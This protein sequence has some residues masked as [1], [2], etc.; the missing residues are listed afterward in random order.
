[1]VGR[2]RMKRHL[3][4][5]QLGAQ[6]EEAHMSVDEGLVASEEVGR[7]RR[8]DAHRKAHDGVVA[9]GHGRLEHGSKVGMDDL[10]LGEARAELVGVL[11]E[12]PQPWQEAS[13]LHLHGMLDARLWTRV[14]DDGG[15]ELPGR[16]G[17][18]LAADG[19]VGGWEK[20]AHGEKKVLV[21]NRLVRRG[22]G[23]LCAR[24]EMQEVDR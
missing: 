22:D 3:H 21:S 20:S 18:G 4:D 1:M 19:G 6:D 23:E 7:L 9:L 10:G 16:G 8:G 5:Q 11:A 12:H 14:A 2:D 24:R 13:L 17:Q 15:R